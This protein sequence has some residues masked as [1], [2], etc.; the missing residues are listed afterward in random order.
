MWLLTSRLFSL[1]LD[2]ALDA[3]VLLV[4]SCCG[5]DLCEHLTG[6]LGSTLLQEPART[7]RQEEEAYKLQ[8][9]R[10]C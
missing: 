10:D 2:D 8:H 9:G 7:L 3:V 4:H 5:S 1:F 6:L